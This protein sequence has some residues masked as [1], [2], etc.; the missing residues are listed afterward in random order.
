MTENDIL[1]AKKGSVWSPSGSLSRRLQPPDTCSTRPSHAVRGSRGCS[2]GMAPEQDFHAPFMD[3][4]EAPEQ[5]W[6]PAGSQQI[7]ADGN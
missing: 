1:W 4:P 3:V 5:H 2:R 7:F 6:D